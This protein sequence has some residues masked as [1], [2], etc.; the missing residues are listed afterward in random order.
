LIAMPVQSY[1]CTCLLNRAKDKALSASVI[2]VTYAWH[3]MFVT[4]TSHA[5]RQEGCRWVL[6]VPPP[7]TPTNH[8]VGTTWSLQ[9]EVLG[10]L[11]P[12][13]LRPDL[14][15]SELQVA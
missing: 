14:G 4:Q 1:S 7:Q 5:T 2:Y 11:F 12:V 9:A 8:G 13:Q 3:Y 10:Q 15:M 6:G